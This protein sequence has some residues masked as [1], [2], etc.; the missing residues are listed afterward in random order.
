VI[1]RA[2]R[3]TSAALLLAIAS[4]AHAADWELS[5]YASIEPRVFLERPQFPGQTARGLSWSAVLAP[6]LRRE[7]GDGANR[8]TIAPFLRI[9]EH[10]SERSHADLREAA[11]QHV[12][13]PWTFVAGLSK[14]FWGVAESRHLVDIVNQTDLVEDIAGE[15]KLGQPMIRIE[16]WTGH[17]SFG[18]FLLPGF[19]ERTFPADDARLRGALPIAT[20][21][22]KYQSGAGRRRVD[23]ALRWA[24][25]TGPWD[26]GLSAFHGTSREPR[27][28]P[29][30]ISPTRIALVPHY[31]V[32]TQAGVDTQ[33]TRGAWLWKLETIV[34]RGHG[35]R[36]AAAVGGFEYTF[37]GVGG[38][39]VDLGVL[40][41]YLYDGRSAHAPPTIHDDDVFLGVRL[42]LNDPDGTMVLAGA[43]IDRSGAGSSAKLQAER[44]IGA[45]WKVELEARIFSGV[46]PEDRLLDGIRKDSF[47]TLRIARYF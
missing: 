40:A 20:D 41:E 8:L 21:R 19:R 12:S 14:V 37:F 39:A 47:F 13:G 4:I 2:L 10:D 46:K 43:L 35:T 38:S 23:V 27:L 16:R 18:A 30:P 1:T 17:G 44:R 33:Y 45:A 28:V 36:F 9:D 31:D 15:D 6:E 11:W 3:G 7:W 22:A 24:H 25:S 5:G 34:R 42:T 32:I 26:V 29:T